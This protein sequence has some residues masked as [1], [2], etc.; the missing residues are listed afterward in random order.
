MDIDKFYKTLDN[1]RKE[2]NKVVTDLRKFEKEASFVDGIIAEKVPVNVANV[3]ERL[4]NIANGE[5]QGSLGY[6]INII[7]GVSGADLLS[8]DTKMARQAAA[9]NAP[10]VD[11]TPHVGNGPQS[12][13]MGESKKRT[14]SDFYKKSKMQESGLV[15]GNILDFNEVADQMGFEDEPE[16]T[17]PFFD[18]INDYAFD[19][20]NDS[21]LDDDNYYGN[22]AP[23]FNGNFDEFANDLDPDGMSFDDI[24]TKFSE[25]ASDF[26]QGEEL[27]PIDSLDQSANDLPPIE[28]DDIGDP[29]PS[30]APADTYSGMPD[31]GG[32]TLGE[33]G[34]DDFPSIDRE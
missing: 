2:L 26:V 19:S 23:Q 33:D 34:N 1:A 16:D 21:A 11:T 17:N 4:D 13:L 5:A 7:L 25:P 27:P 18:E 29:I 6:V 10:K 31:F 9:S 14:L 30:P 28:G 22:E 24:K 8:D 3:R 15:F 12:A 32:D 20:S